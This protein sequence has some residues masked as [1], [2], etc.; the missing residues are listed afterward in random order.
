M[1]NETVAEK[2]LKA[3]EMVAKAEAVEAKIAAAHKN[4]LR[5]RADLDK[6]R[7]KIRIMGWRL[8]KDHGVCMDTDMLRSMPHS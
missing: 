2:A 7:G 3:S 6:T 4:L 1:T 5:A 8:P